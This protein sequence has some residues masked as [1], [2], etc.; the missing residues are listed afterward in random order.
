MACRS[1]RAWCASEVHD[2]NVDVVVSR[3]SSFFADDRSLFHLRRRCCACKTMLDVRPHSKVSTQKR[4]VS[5]KEVDYG[6][7]WKEETKVP[8]MGFG[9]NT[10][11]GNLS[12][13]P[14]QACQSSVDP[15]GRTKRRGQCAQYLRS[16]HDMG[17]RREPI[18]KPKTQI[19]RTDMQKQPIR[20]PCQREI[21]RCH[22][23]MK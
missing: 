19:P 1:L 17:P 9:R 15:S 22:V 2:G 11:E 16:L 13:G 23:S 20:H 3:C 7:Q 6:G 4:H 21:R 14:D 18:E 12:K 8:G 10:H 5:I